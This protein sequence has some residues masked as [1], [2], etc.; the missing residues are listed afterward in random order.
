MQARAASLLVAASAFAG[1]ALTACND[2]GRTLRDARPDQ[3]ASVST[4]APPTTV[5]P[6]L[7]PADSELV[8][9][10]SLPI[11]SGDL[12]SPVAP[13]TADLPLIGVVQAPWPNE[14]AIPARHTCDGLDVAPALQW[15]PSPTGTVEIAVTLVDQDA[16]DFVHWVMTGIDPFATSLAEGEIPEFATVGVNSEGAAG[17]AGPCPLP[18]E[19]H[20]YVYTVH[21]LDQ[22]SELGDG[23]AGADLQA[24]VNGAT[25]ESL[26]VV[27]TYSRS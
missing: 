26:S 2:D 5:D 12:G 18:G 25:F 3:V 23:A 10:P 1:I 22:V 7:G 8:P 13:D 17:Y 27:G 4:T 21:F 20:R 24:F 6:L 19:T 14:G 9:V 16:P 11:D 15:A